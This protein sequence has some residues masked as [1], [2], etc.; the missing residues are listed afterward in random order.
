[1]FAVRITLARVSASTPVSATDRLRRSSR[2]SPFRASQKIATIAA[3][4]F[5]KS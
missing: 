5:R 2:Y 4:H 3:L 1:M